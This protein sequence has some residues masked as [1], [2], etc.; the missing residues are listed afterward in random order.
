MKPMHGAGLVVSFSASL[1]LGAC[2]GGSGGRPPVP[3]EPIEITEDNASEVAA[4]VPMTAAL[5]EFQDFMGFESLT[6]E[7]TG[8]FDCPD[9][10]SITAAFQVD[11]V[12]LGVVSTGDRFTVDFHDCMLDVSSRINGGIAID[13]TTISGDWTVDDTWNVDIDFQVNDLTFSSGPASGFFD[14]SWTQST[15]FDMGDRSF[16][17][18]GDFATSVNDGVQYESAVLNDLELTWAYDSMAGIATY[19][20]DGLFASTALGGSVLITTLTPFELRDID[21]F[22]Y[23]GSIRATGANGSTLTFTALDEVFVQ[24]DVDADGD[25]VTDFT[26]NT[27][28]I[29]LES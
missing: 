15:G 5:I 13:F 1:F 19:S 16:A 8:T 23:K 10:G 7:G 12:P 2:S 9:G 22:C 25:T 24:I 20:V 17:L 6:A 3:T 26:L 29:E 14:G 21:S 4:G 11:V 18:A 27:T 28:W